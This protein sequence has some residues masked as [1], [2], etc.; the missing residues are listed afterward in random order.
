MP[1]N[2]RVTT[3][4]SHSDI[5]TLLDGIYYNES[6][7]GSIPLAYIPRPVTGELGGYQIRPGTL[8]LVKQV[9]PEQFKN[10]NYLDL[11]DD[12]IGREVAKAY[13][14]INKNTLIAKGFTPTDTLLL[15]SYNGGHGVFKKNTNIGAGLQAYVDSATTYI[16]S[17]RSK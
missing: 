11:K 6:R 1:K 7:T 13:T 17:K 3:S 12:S 15:A 2:N 10:I 9:Y 14:L 8:D 16:N 4:L 5:D